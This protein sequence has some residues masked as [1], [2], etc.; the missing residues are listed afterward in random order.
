MSSEAVPEQCFRPVTLRATVRF[1]DAQWARAWV[2]GAT[3]VYNKSQQAS[4]MAV[5]CC[6]ALTSYRR[7]TYFRSRAFNYFRCVVQIAVTRSKYT[8]SIDT[9]FSAWPMS[10]RAPLLTPL[11]S[12]AKLSCD[13]TWVFRYQ[14]FR[15]PQYLATLP[16][17]EY[18]ICSSIS[19]PA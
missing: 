15:A 13:S 9:R 2:L 11:E 7:C 12:L 14:D 19:W 6:T 18:P 8:G 10:N 3:R 4:S 16:I 5:T 1:Q 17:A